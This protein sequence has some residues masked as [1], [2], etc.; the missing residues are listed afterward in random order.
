MRPRATSASLQLVPLRPV[1]EAEGS[2]ACASGAAWASQWRSRLRA[3]RVSASALVCS[4]RCC[5]SDLEGGRGVGGSICCCG[6]GLSGCSGR[7]SSPSAAGRCTAGASM[8]AMPGGSPLPAPC[9]AADA[10][11]GWAAARCAARSC[12]CCAGGGAQPSGA[13]PAAPASG[14][15]GPVR[16]GAASTDGAPGCGS[17]AGMAAGAAPGVSSR[18]AGWAGGYCV[19]P[20]SAS[21]PAVTCGAVSCA[22]RSARPARGSTCGGRCLLFFGNST[23]H[24]IVGA[25]RLA[26]AASCTCCRARHGTDSLCSGNSAWAAMLQDCHR[27]G[28]IA[29]KAAHKGRNPP[30]LPV[31]SSPGILDPPGFY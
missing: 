12:C 25:S 21:S 7:R 24:V 2:A 9:L 18:A 10:G 8:A 31:R 19:F 11:C 22:Q 27:M 20:T 23:D 14:A 4:A 1:A 28:S 29:S 3:R 16:S 6:G 13:P 26:D 17:G 15:A 30:P 5:I